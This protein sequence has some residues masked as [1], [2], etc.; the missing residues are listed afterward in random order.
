[1]AP[2]C[3]FTERNLS[4]KRI[5]GLQKAVAKVSGSFVLFFLFPSISFLTP[6]PFTSVCILY[7]K[8]ILERKLMVRAFKCFFSPC[9]DRNAGFTEWTKA[10]GLEVDRL[11]FKSLFHTCYS[12]IFSDESDGAVCQLLVRL[13]EITLVVF[14][15]LCLMKCSSHWCQPMGAVIFQDEEPDLWP[16]H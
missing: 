7:F 12:E 6:S 11:Q 16:L 10:V 3:H 13:I 9:H 14:P 15:A 2:L 5:T 8:N 4:S 1:M